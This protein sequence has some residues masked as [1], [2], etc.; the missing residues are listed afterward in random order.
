[1]RVQLGTAYK[2][3]INMTTSATHAITGAFGYSGKYIAK[4]LL[5]DGHHVVTLTQSPDR[6]HPFGD[7]VTA[8]PLCF[9]DPKRLTQQPDGVDVLYITY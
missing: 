4:R 6:P 9:D 8:M 3:G 1:M 2:R 7:R 5:E